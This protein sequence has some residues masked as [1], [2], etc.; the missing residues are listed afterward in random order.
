MKSN[1]IDDSSNVD[2]CK[3]FIREEE[4]IITKLHESNICDVAYHTYHI[5]NRWH[6][7]SDAAGFSDPYTYFAHKHGF[8]RDLV[9]QYCRIGKVIEEYS[10]YLSDFDLKEIRSPYHLLHF[11]K[12]VRL[13][14]KYP[15]EYS[16]ETTWKALTELSY[17]K[18]VEYTKGPETKKPKHKVKTQKDPLISKEAIAGYHE[19]LRTYFDNGLDVFIIAAADT[20]HK[21]RIFS[22]MERRLHPKEIQNIKYVTT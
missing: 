15:Y 21:E 17:R 19:T 9:R 18:F 8:K 6:L 13:Y 4:L 7:L 1:K 11:G 14:E 22:E 10:L 5:K 12:A 2:S 16:M 3:D 20:T